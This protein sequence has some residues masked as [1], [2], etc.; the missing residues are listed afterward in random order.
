MRP[1]Q[2]WAIGH[3]NPKTQ[4]AI[5]K[6]YKPHR[7]AKPDLEDNLGPYCGYCEVCNTTAQVDHIESQDQDTKKEKIYLWE[8][9]ILACG[10]CN[11]ADNKTSKKVDFKSMYFPDKNNTLMAF[12]YQEGV[13]DGLYI[14]GLFKLGNLLIQTWVIPNFIT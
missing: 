10:N 8:N 4:K 11:G 1:I 5:I 13:L 9:F 12:T 14:D 7:T 3:I 2:K 6:E